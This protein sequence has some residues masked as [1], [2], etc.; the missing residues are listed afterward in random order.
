MDAEMLLPSL[1]K[2]G[3]EEGE[4]P[5]L[6]LLRCTASLSFPCTT[7]VSLVIEE[8]GKEKVGKHREV[9]EM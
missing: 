3:K 4:R 5:V 7:G 8:I 9:A 2:G 6:W 1:P